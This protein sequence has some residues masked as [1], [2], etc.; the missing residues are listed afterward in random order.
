M[1]NNGCLHTAYRLCSRHANT[2]AS[3]RTAL[4]AYEHRCKYANTVA[5]LAPTSTGQV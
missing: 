3:I 5:G 1:L 2:V 4:L